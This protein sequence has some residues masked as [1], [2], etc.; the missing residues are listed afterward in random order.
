M[1]CDMVIMGALDYV[2]RNVIEKL[3][4]PIGIVIQN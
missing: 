2:N 4:I 3:V 1:H